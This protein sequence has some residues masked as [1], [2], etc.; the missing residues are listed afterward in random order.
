MNRI[1]DWII[2]RLKRWSRYD[3]LEEAMLLNR[4]GASNIDHL[5]TMIMMGRT[6]EPTSWY[7]SEFKTFPAK[8]V[9][10]LVLLR[11]TRRIMSREDREA[12]AKA[13]Y[14]SNVRRDLEAKRAHR[15]AERMREYLKNIA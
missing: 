11:K 6:N 4:Y 15:E 14:K 8:I 7:E 3:E 10:K 12:S 9:S 2:D 5:Y 1:I 13:L